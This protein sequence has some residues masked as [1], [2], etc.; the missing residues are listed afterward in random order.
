MSE[1]LELVSD[2]DRELLADLAG[3]RAGFEFRIDELFLERNEYDL[4]AL[5]RYRKR[6]SRKQHNRFWN[7]LL[8]GRD[9]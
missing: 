3:F 7:R 8:S 5:K 4:E 9:C 2:Q 6:P 1:Q